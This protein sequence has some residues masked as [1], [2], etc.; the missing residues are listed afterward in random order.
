M[1]LLCRAIREYPDRFDIPGFIVWRIKIGL[2]NASVFPGSGVDEAQRF[3]GR[4]GDDTHMSNNAVGAVGAGKQ[5]YVTWF[6][7]L[8]RYWVFNGCEI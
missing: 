2:Y 1:F 3:A 6:S 4:G 8:Q 7:L 5:D